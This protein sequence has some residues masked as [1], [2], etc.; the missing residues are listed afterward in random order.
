M[1][2]IALLIITILAITTACSEDKKPEFE[3]RRLHPIVVKVEKVVYKEYDKQLTYS[4]IIEADKTIPLSFQTSG[5]IESVFVDEG[6]FVKKGQ[7]IASA[8]KQSVR[9]AYNAAIAQY[10]Q[11]LDAHK[12]LKSVYDAGSLPKI[13]WVEIESKVIQAE[14]NKNI[15]KKS[16][17][18][19]DM[20]AP[21]DGYIGKRNLEVGMSAVQIQAPIELVK[22][23]KVLVSTS[24]PENV[25]N[26]FEIGQTAMVKIGALGNMNFSG[27]VENIGVVANQMSRTYQ[28]KIGLENTNNAIKPGMVCEVILSKPVNKHFILLPLTS[29]NKINGSEAYL[30]T[31]DINTKRV[32]R[33]EIKLG[34]LVGN[35]IEIISGVDEGDIV[36]TSGAQK[37]TENSVVKF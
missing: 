33:K 29:I 5:V 7:L 23:E 27:I 34:E 15:Y 1:N 6:D 36:V 9:N 22:L 13:K 16:L 2:K 18:N 25:I 31:V 35:S 17:E 14:A 3:N 37:I 28:L 19:C 20:R 11:A 12:R 26:S 8:E 21:E 10:N 30:F 4:G 32:K 24:I